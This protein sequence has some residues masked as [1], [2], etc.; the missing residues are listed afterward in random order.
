MSEHL[1]LAIHAISVNTAKFN[2]VQFLASV[3]IIM[4]NSTIVSWMLTWK[5]VSHQHLHVWK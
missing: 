3:I 5:G 4:F 1:H 2:R